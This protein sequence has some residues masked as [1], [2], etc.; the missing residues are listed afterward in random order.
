MRASVLL[1]VALLAVTGCG[2]APRSDGPRFVAA[3]PSLRSQC[4]AA[5][6]RVGYAV[7][8]P[9][10]VPAGLTATGVAGPTAC[11]LEIVGA[12]GL[13]GCARSWR[14]WVVGSSTVGRQHL[15]L[16]GSP[17][18]LAS[19]AK[20]VNGPAWYPKARVRTLGRTTIGAWRMRIVFVPAATNDGSA[21]ASHVVLIW[22]VG[23]HTYGIGFHDVAGLERTARLDEELARGI[24]LVGP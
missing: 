7:P 24:E 10:R 14:G 20:L 17:R 12:G 4:R 3:P 19:A 11:R 16:T 22:T 18:P 9:T 6:R 13:G 15:V 5:A 1:A 8:C 21:F 23:G 2:K